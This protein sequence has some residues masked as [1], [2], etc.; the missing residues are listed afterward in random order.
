MCPMS[1]VCVRSDQ[2][3]GAID[4]RLVPDPPISQMD[5]DALAGVY[6]LRHVDLTP[7]RLS[8]DGRYCAF[9]VDRTSVWTYDL[10]SRSLKRVAPPDEDN[11]SLMGPNGRRIWPP[12]LMVR[13]LARSPDNTL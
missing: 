12:F 10:D 4:I 11:V 7:T 13:D 6:D 5:D 8:E 3:L 1:C 9:A 2:K